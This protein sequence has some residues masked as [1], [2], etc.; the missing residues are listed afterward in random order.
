MSSPG[1]VTPPPPTPSPF[2]A[3]ATRPAPPLSPPPRQPSPGAQRMR[4]RRWVR[5]RGEDMEGTSVGC[6]R[7]RANRKVGVQPGGVSAR[8]GSMCMS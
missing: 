6:G 3:C 4:G 1:D 2:R 7:V 5:G 8:W